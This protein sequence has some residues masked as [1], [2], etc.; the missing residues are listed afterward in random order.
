MLHVSVMRM[1]CSPSREQLTV[2]R[3]QRGSVGSV[4]VYK[5]CSDASLCVC[6]CSV[7]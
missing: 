3:K 7:Y 5:V 4:C 2:E 6:V 1:P